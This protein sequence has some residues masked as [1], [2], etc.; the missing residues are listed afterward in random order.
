MYHLL[1]SLAALI[2]ALIT[3]NAFADGAAPQRERFRAAYEALVA[4]EQID[5]AR[6]RT[7]LQGYVL[8]PYIEYYYLRKHL[9]HVSD[10]EVLAFLEKHDDL[11]VATLLR[12]AWLVRLGRRGDWEQFLAHYQPTSAAK[13]NCFALRAQARK[14]GV[15]SDWIERAKKLW[16]VGH[17]QPDACNPVFAELYSR[18]ALSSR[19]V[20]RRVELAMAAGNKH[21]ARYLERY[22][23]AGDAAWLRRWLE[24]D[25]QPLA[26]LRRPQFD[27][28][29]WRAGVLLSHAVKK[30]AR[31]DPARAWEMLPMLREHRTL[32]DE[33]IAALYRYVALRSAYRRH[34]KALDWLDAVPEQGINDEVRV[35]QATLARGEQLWPRLLQAIEE[36]PRK[37][38]ERAE[39]RYWHAYALDQVGQRQRAEEALSEL[40][41]E[42]SYYGFLAADALNRP[43]NMNATSVH[44]ADE[45]LAEIAANP[46]IQ[47]ALELF[48][49]HLLVDARREWQAAVAAFDSDRKARAAVVAANAGWYDRAIITANGA[50]LHDALDLRFPIAFRDRVEHYSRKN[51]LELSLTLALLRKESAFMPDAVSPAGALGLMQVMPSTG[52]QVARQLNERLPSSAAL[53]DVD[54]NLRLGSAYLRQ[55]LDRFDNNPVLA[56]AAYNAGPH[57]VDAWLERNAYQ[58][59]ALWVE[60][61]SFRE[62]RQYVKDVLAFSTVFDWQLN[63]SRSRRITDLMMPGTRRE[64][65]CN[66][67]E[68]WEAC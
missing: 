44:F 13:L 60:N 36:L 38:Q 34:A 31:R 29:D 12:N 39:W 62:T 10:E 40:A 35:W 65:A 42:R 64:T 3:T 14:G 5:R 67:P 23:D 50:G 16:M 32:S 8:A 51:R 27:R 20:W 15:D 30:L 59:P 41:A 47:R 45:E 1:R 54:T 57:R 61:I 9:G 43:Y 68:L 18:K 11:P 46:F 66:P 7:E 2:L 55:V 53:L 24:V 22:L 37:E 26:A 19:E 63:G 17:S 58:P 4:G 56:A 6:L 49:L 25:R 48:R 33:E 21:L 52:R 28:S